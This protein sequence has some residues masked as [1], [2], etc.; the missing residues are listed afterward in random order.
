MTIASPGRIPGHSISRH[1]EA[2]RTVR[3]VNQKC[4]RADR[5]RGII[6]R[7]AERF[8]NS[9]SSGQCGAA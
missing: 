7:L 6:M 9:P 1:G 8:Y 2:L 5:S 3:P 4:G